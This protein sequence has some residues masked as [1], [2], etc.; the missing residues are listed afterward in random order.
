MN[1]LSHSSPLAAENLWLCCVNFRQ[2]GSDS[3]RAESGCQGIELF[4]GGLLDGPL[5]FDNAVD[6]TAART[7][8]L[9]SPVAGKAD[10]LVAPDLEAGNMRAKQMTY[11]ADAEG[12]GVIVGARV[13]IIL[14][15][16]ADNARTR[17]ASCALAVLMAS[18]QLKGTAMRKV[19][20]TA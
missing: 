16:R 13:P 12:T 10:I 1:P 11:L 17:G 6:E 4:G 8:G 15:S 20:G 19:A 3:L 9:V 18:A 7:K 5:A 2:A 14:T